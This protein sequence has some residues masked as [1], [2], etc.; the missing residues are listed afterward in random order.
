MSLEADFIRKKVRAVLSNHPNGLTFTQ[1]RKQL[2]QNSPRFKDLSSEEL[3]HLLESDPR[4]SC[5]NDRY[6]LSLELSSS[7]E[8]PTVSRP[9][10]SETVPATRWDLFRRLCKYYID[11]L[12][13]SSA[14]SISLSPEQEGRKFCAIAGGHNYWGN[15]CEK[16]PFRIRLIGD[17]A[18]F[19]LHLKT[20]I[21]GPTVLLASPVQF[22]CWTQKNTGELKVFYLP[23]L[24]QPATTKIEGEF[25]QFTPLGHPRVNG[26]WLDSEFRGQEQ[27]NEFLEK[28]GLREPEDGNNFGEFEPKLKEAHQTL[29]ALLKGKFKEH[30]DLTRFPE[31]PGFNT[32]CQ[33]EHTGLYHRLWVIAITDPMFTRGLIKDLDDIAAVPDEELD[34]TALRSLFPHDPP[35]NPAPESQTGNEEQTSTIPI[36]VQELNDEQEEAVAVT[37][38]HPLTKITGPPGT[39][40]STVVRH[41]ILNALFENRKTLFS[42]TNHQALEAVIPQLNALTHTGF[43]VVHSSSKGG[44]GVEFHELLS[45][46]LDLPEQQNA[47]PEYQKTLE[48]L[49]TLNRSITDLRDVITSEAEL[50]DRYCE[51]E[52]EIVESSKQLGSDDNLDLKYNPDLPESA[53]LEPPLQDLERH[54]QRSPSWFYRIWRKFFPVADPSFQEARGLL[55]K[56][57][58]QPFVGLQEI[59]VITLQRELKNMTPLLQRN[60]LLKEQ[61]N[62]IAA[63]SRHPSRTHRIDELDQ[64]WQ[65][66][67][68][69]VKQLIGHW[70]R[71][72]NQDLSA[73]ELEFWSTLKA[74]IKTYGNQNSAPGKIREKFREHLELLLHR[75]PAWATTSL[76]ARRSI[77]LKPAVFDDLLIDEASQCDI[78]SVVP[79]LFRSKNAIAVGDPMQLNVTSKIPRKE[80]LQ[81]LKQSRLDDAD[82]ARY[83]FTSGSFF[84]LVSGSPELEMENRVQ[85]K[86]HYRC[87]PRLSDYFNRMFYQDTLVVRTN[88]HRL[89]YP[90]NCQEPC[91]WTDLPSKIEPGYPRSPIDLGQAKAVVQELKRLEAEDYDGTVGV[92]APFRRQTDRIQD[93]AHKELRK[94]T[95]Q[96]WDLVIH[97]VDGFQ[98]G[99][100]DLILFSLVGGADMPRGGLWFLKN[101]K[102]R[103][104]VAVSRARAVLHIFGDQQW[105]GNCE[106]PHIQQLAQLPTHSEQQRFR[107][108]LVGPVW[109][110]LLAEQMKRHGLEFTQQ[111]HTQGFYLDFA[112]FK[113]DL[114][115]NIEVDGETYHKDASGRRRGEDLYRDRILIASGWKVLRFWVYELKEDI[116]RCL[117][118]I[119]TILQ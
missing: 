66:E 99:E 35:Q 32:L 22:K 101:D 53:S 79:L 64:A 7:S 38:R 37:R 97:T 96:N 54:L 21:T 71:S 34:R 110:P 46:L 19:A 29:T 70:W 20:T 13:L 41:V 102:N 56:C 45:A 67:E 3:M 90:G 1:L 51:L 95:I 50:K 106:I 114:K 113:G 82:L 105:A 88:T 116:D 2:L 23:V 12:Y 72:R 85:L 61:E 94:A 16:T 117:N 98:G 42:S 18:S 9:R 74:I 75:F 5:Q 80:H 86:E 118:E 73:G 119:D 48:E 44:S 84:D 100:R 87:H 26:K 104:N 43:V 30:P 31:A 60:D 76:S 15:V 33:P 103:F 89:R 69:L 59:D 57:S 17:L 107:S 6:S 91:Q 39:G 40:K 47:V 112:I 27:Q 115:L 78:A 63:I 92:I 10:A 36:Q 65:Q 49:R 109:E 4:F 58:P 93:L 14:Q 28:L 24:L 52:V 111:Y 77:P 108:D 11:C 55:Q 83:W 25:I 81:L 62:S 68:P 8:E